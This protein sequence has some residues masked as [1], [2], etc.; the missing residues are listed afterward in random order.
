MIILGSKLL[1][2]S[3]NEKLKPVHSMQVFT[4]LQTLLSFAT[5]LQTLVVIN[6]ESCQTLFPSICVQSS[7]VPVLFDWNL[8]RLSFLGYVVNLDLLICTRFN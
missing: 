5:I 6:A 8:S 2:K 1:Q 7:E 3:L 4:C